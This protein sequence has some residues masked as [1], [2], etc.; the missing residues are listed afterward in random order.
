MV[1]SDDHR[2]IIPFTLRSS[3]FNVMAINVSR[4]Y[5]ASLFIHICKVLLMINDDKKTKRKF[6]GEKHCFTIV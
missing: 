3:L 6:S 5:N 1:V 2:A 4:L